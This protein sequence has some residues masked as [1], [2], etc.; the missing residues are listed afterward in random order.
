MTKLPDETTP[1]VNRKDQRRIEAQAREARTKIL[2]PLE[3]ELES[4]EEK[5]AEQEAAQAT[6][7]AALSN[8]DISSDSE[9]LRST[10]NAVEKITKTLELAFTRWSA[11]TEEIEQVKAKHGL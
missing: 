7:T 4:L 3:K 6:L 2:A 10:T 5:I 1:G 9:K 11:L 8:P